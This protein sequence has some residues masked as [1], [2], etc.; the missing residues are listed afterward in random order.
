[1]TFSPE[2][3]A[4][5]NQLGV[6]RP[7]EY[8]DWVIIVLPAYEHPRKEPT[9]RLWA[10][11]NGFEVIH[12]VDVPEPWNALIKAT[13]A[14]AAPVDGK[15]EVGSMVKYF[16]TT[17]RNGGEVSRPR[18]HSGGMYMPTPRLLLARLPRLV[19]NSELWPAK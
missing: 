10:A 14:A 8:T 7:C 18:D 19:D 12:G 11:S 16:L 17:M 9:C 1:M 15:W 13:G 3:V 4:K 6:L 2:M 5:L